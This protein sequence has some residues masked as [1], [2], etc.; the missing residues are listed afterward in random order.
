[1]LFARLPSWQTLFELILIIAVIAWVVRDP[2][3]AAHHV[4][5]FFHWASHV[6]SQL[7]VFFTSI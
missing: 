5:G 4:S 2:A 6:L 1:M 3:G 7:T